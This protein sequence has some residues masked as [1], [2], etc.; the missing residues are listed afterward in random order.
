MS[1]TLDYY[2]RV[3]YSSLLLKQRGQL[4]MSLAF[5]TRGIKTTDH[6]ADIFLQGSG[7]ASVST[8]LGFDPMNNVK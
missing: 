6:G 5:H 1:C 8:Q 3:K 2:I 7:R 4:M